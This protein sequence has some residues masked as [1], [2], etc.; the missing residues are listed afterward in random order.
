MASITAATAA[1][2]AAATT[3][4]L[5]LRQSTA[6]QLVLF[7]H[8]TTSCASTPPNTAAAVDRTQPQARL[9]DMDPQLVTN[10]RCAGVNADLA[11]RVAQ[12]LYEECFEWTTLKA[13]FHRGGDAAV[14]DDLDGID[15]VNKG[16]TSKIITYLHQSAGGS[17]SGS[18]SSS[19]A[20]SSSS[21][22]PQ[23]LPQSGQSS[24]STRAL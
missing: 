4:P 18:G 9:E 17:S 23:P 6:S 15:G 13:A 1:I 3:A 7:S 22:L 12:S 14:R 5:C 10:L 20:A 2:A 24:R 21:S 8:T 19:S 11:E 16:V